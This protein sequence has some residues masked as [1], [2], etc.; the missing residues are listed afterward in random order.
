MGQQKTSLAG[1]RQ[2]TTAEVVDFE[3]AKADRLNRRLAASEFA[4]AMALA[5]HRTDGASLN[6]VL[7]ALIAPFNNEPR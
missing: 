1:W 5:E 3:T 4:A 2:R 6:D 7:K